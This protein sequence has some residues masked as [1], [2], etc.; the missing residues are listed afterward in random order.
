[1]QAAHPFGITA[2]QVIIDG[3]DVHAF[4][5][6]CIEV[7]GQRRNQ[8]FTLPRTHFGD[9]AVMEHHTADQLHIE[10]PHAE[11]TLTGFTDN[12]KGFGQQGIECFATG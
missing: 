1:M 5:S 3:N 7:G 12:R 9:L 6:Q 4:A 10:V 11:H 8:G 2:R